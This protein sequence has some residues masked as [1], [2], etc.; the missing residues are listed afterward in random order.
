VRLKIWVLPEGKKSGID[1][2][3]RLTPTVGVGMK[4]KVWKEL[5]FGIESEIFKANTITLGNA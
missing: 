4:M 5:K 1:L 2:L 3:S